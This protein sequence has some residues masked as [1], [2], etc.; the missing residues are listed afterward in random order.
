MFADLLQAVIIVNVLASTIR[1][2]TP[3]LLSATGELLTQRAGV[4]NLGIEGTMLVGATV[5]FLAANLTES[6][7][8]ALVAAL[9]A[10]GLMSLILV[11]MATNLKV[12][13]TVTG[14]SLNLF[15]SGITLY[16]YR[17][18]YSGR[19]PSESPVIATLQ[20]LPLPLLSQ[21][22]Y[23]GEILFNQR[24]LTYVALLTVPALWFFL[25]RTRYGLV[26]RSIGENPRAADLRGIPLL[27]Y[28]YAAVI[29]GG[30]M[31]G[32]AGSFLTLGS[33]AKFVPE[34]S[35]GR[36]WLVLVIIIAGNWHPAGILIATLAFAFL[37]A[38]QLQ[39]QGVGV[40]IPYQFLL[41]LPYVVAILALIGSRAKSLQPRA[42][43]VPYLRE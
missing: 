23:I 28:Q 11:A 29:F 21:L 30:M 6:F 2:A 24:F 35:A 34:I 10:G 42:L 38:L 40:T 13:Q 1:I 7:W 14:L 16:L 4:L 17:V 20:P 41:A 27:G 18:A 36:G 19:P 3:L 12:D 39:V 37:D 8:I 33:S 15:A 26:L 43:G 25:Y 22:P 32:L 9:V 31:T 5:A